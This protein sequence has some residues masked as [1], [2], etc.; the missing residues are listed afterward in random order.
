[1]VAVAFSP[2]G[3]TVVTGSDDKT[4]RLWEASSGKLLATL[5]HRDWVGAVAFS[6]DGRTVVTGSDSPDGRSVVIGR[7]NTLLLW[8]ASSGKLLATHK[9]WGRAVAFSP[10][11]DSVLTGI[12]ARTAALWHQVRPGPDAPQRLRAW[13]KVRTGKTLDNDGALRRLTLAEWLHA[14]QELERLG[15]EWE[16][17]C[18]SRGCDRAEANEAERARNWFATAF[19]LQRLLKAEP[20]E[21]DLQHRLG[22]AFA[23]QGNWPDAIAAF[24]EACRLEP[25]KHW[26]DYGLA[27]LGAGDEAG[28]R[29][30]C[31][32]IFT[33]YPRATK[34]ETADLLAWLIALRPKAVDEM[35]MNVV[36]ELVE[37]AV[38]ADPKSRA[39]REALG[40]V[41]CRMKAPTAAVKQLEEAIKLNH[42]ETSVLIQLFLAMSCHQQGDQEKAQKLLNTAKARI[43]DD[44]KKP[45]KDQ[46]FWRERLQRRLL[47]QEAEELVKSDGAQRKP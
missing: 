8:E 20:Q 22:N 11:G 37:G 15:G 2:N 3:R 19:H 47:L 34:A 30:L 32:R 35:K 36:R 4:A 13:V 39:Y 6:P 23:E 45:L 28:Y 27:K 25:D 10:A 7:E 18:D 43:D 14:W 16:P 44:L 33:E 40:A 21:A 26:Y 31:A 5:Q 17:L 42:G 29:E 9:R 1:V 24:A 12:D 38:K 41:L 46:P